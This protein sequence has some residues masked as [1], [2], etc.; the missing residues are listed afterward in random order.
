MMTLTRGRSGLMARRSQNVP[1]IVVAHDDVRGISQIQRRIRHI[2]VHHG[3][4]GHGGAAADS[5][6]ADDPCV[7]ADPDAVTDDW[8]R[9]LWCRGD[10][11]EATD[12]AIG[13]DAAAA[14]TDGAEVS[15]V[16]PGTYVRRQ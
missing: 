1:I 4:G 13:A 8:S 7:R 15:D 11:G 2:L 9:P 6:T 14:H 12:R 3:T 10:V 5:I 16:E